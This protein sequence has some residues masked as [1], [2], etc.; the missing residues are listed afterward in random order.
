MKNQPLLLIVFLALFISCSQSNSKNESET[1]D[2]NITPTEDDR[3]LIDSLLDSL[4]IA[5]AN[6]DYDGYFGFYTED[7][8][9]CGTDATEN[10]DKASFMVWAKPYFDNKTTW[11]FTSIE[12]NV[13]FA[14]N[15]ELAW[16]DELLNTQMKICRG[17]G[18]VVKQNNEWKIQHY[19]LSI[20]VPNSD[21]AQV[22][23]IKA[24]QED[25]LINVISNSQ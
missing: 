16:F 8:V 20:T 7:A 13:Y 12:R 23:D 1:I 6:A 21:I 14:K 10:W 11:D 15:N 2:N 17:S 25:S 22:I 4:N 18:V 24:A 5:A 19:V 3:M 9:F